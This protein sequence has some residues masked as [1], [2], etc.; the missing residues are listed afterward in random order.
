MI[1]VDGKPLFA[2]FIDAVKRQGSG[3]VPYEWSKPG[4]DH[5]LPKFSYVQG[6]APWGW[7]I[8]TGVYIDD[9]SR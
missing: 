5:P 2:L 6:F 3:F 8:G 7:V 4:V 9:I 1:N